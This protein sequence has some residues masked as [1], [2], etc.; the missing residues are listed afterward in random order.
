VNR[1]CLLYY[2]FSCLLFLQA[3]TGSKGLTLPAELS[4]NNRSS[5][6]TGSARYLPNIRLLDYRGYKDSVISNQEVDKY[7]NLGLVFPYTR[8][9]KNVLTGEL[10]FGNDSL[11]CLVHYTYNIETHISN[12]QSVL[13]A[14]LEKGNHDYSKDVENVYRYASGR[15][16]ITIPGFADSAWYSFG[17]DSSNTL[18]TNKDSFAFKYV[19][20]RESGSIYVIDGFQ[21][22]KGEVV[23][24]V[25]Q[26][27]STAKLTKPRIYLY[28]KAT[29]REQLVI[30]AYFAI[31]QW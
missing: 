31:R 13:G 25:M 29:A 7:A 18:I 20:E 10:L 2:L 8:I 12:G 4:A 11:K 24:A 22:L 19:K 6:I 21:L 1:T 15:G 3:C 23:Y 30:A 27:Y 26:N 9:T 28:S 5:D 17:R 14:V 16:T